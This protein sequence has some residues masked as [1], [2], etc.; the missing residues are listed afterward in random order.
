M[1]LRLNNLKLNVQKTKCAIFNHEGLFPNVELMVND[2]VIEVIPAFKFL[3]V[4]LDQSL[5]FAKQFSTLYDKL[6][7][8]SFVIRSLSRYVPVK[9][10]RQLYFAYYHSHLTHCSVV[11]WPL[12]NQVSKKL[13]D[14]ITDSTV[15][16]SLRNSESYCYLTRL[17]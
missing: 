1:W 17:W 6:V 3:G 15:C 11:W 12:L 13:F 16:P 4:I 14:Y 9:C 8:S 2:E 7:K 5:S 10:L